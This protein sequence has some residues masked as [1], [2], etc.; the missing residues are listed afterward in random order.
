MRVV[1]LFI[2]LLSQNLFA[3]QD[4]EIPIIKAI[5]EINGTKDKITLMLDQAPEMIAQNWV[6]ESP[7]S[8][9]K[10]AVDEY[11]ASV[12]AAYEKH[13]AWE[14][15]EPTLITAYQRSLDYDELVLL[16]KFVRGD[17]LSKKNQQQWQ[18]MQQELVYLHENVE[19]HLSKLG[20]NVIN[21]LFGTTQGR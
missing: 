21:E 3:S 10:S 20:K 16:L 6:K 13:Y 4:D 12:R 5:L 8:L 2:L 7:Y 9:S 19:F 15:V 18:A 17:Q 11:R 1:L 14:V